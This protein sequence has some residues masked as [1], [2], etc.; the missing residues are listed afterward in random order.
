MRSQFSYFAMCLLLVAQPLKAQSSSEAAAVLGRDVAASRDIGVN[1]KQAVLPSPSEDVSTAPLDVASGGIFVGAINVVGG[2]QI[3]NE[4]YAPA[5][6][7]FVGRR[8]ASADLPAV[9]KSIAD[10]A[11]AKGYIFASALVPQQSVKMGILTVQIEEGAIDEIRIIGSKNRRLQKILDEIRCVAAHKS[12]VERQLLLAGDLPGIEILGT[13][14]VRENGK[15]VLI[16]TAREDRSR[17]SISGDNYGSSSFGPVRVRLEVELTGLLDDGDVLSTQVFATPLQPK[18]LTYIAARYAVPIGNAGTQIALSA[19]AGRT[20]PGYEGIAGTVKGRSR[21]IAIS[22]TQPIIRSNA[23]SLWVSGEVTYLNVEQSLLGILA[24]RDDIVTFSVT[25]SGNVRFAGGRISSGIGIVQG[26]NVLGANIAGDPLS[27]RLDADGSFTKAQLWMN[28][29]RSLGD[30]FSVR[31]AANAQLATSPLLSAQEIG[32]GGSGFGRGYDFSERFGDSGI[33]GLI[34]VRK[35]FEGP[36][37]VINW[38]RVYGFADG[39][40]VY[41]LQSG[42][43]D[44]ALASAGAGV[45]AGIGRAEFGVEAAFPLIDRRFEGNTRTPRINVSAGYSF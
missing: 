3:Q 36:L 4:V 41:N 16:V 33:L 14:Y 44:G 34:E 24:Q 28:W 7:Q 5:A 27:S 18:E 19:S 20:E 38:A 26:L 17:G 37:P 32:V 1:A 10:R 12:D 31:T 40:Y 21:S 30:G 25:A 22:L 2:K 39:G 11:R 6:E 9:A 23:A 13:H 43:G 42:F 35:Y 8:I 45:R 15:G 29:N